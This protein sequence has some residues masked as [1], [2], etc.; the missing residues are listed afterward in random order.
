MIESTGPSPRRI[1]GVV[2]NVR[3]HGPEYDARPEVYL[4][5]GQPGARGAQPLRLVLR[6]RPSAVLSTDR[7]RQIAQAVGP[8]V[9]VGRLRSGSDDLSEVVVRPRHRTMLLSLLGGLGMVLTLV[10]IFSMTAYAVTRRTQEIGI[11]MAF[12][13]EP[14]DVVLTMVRDAAWPAFLGLS[15]GM[16]ARSCHRIIASFRSKRR[17]TIRGRSRACPA[18]GCCGTRRCLGARARAARVDPVIALRQSSA[19]RASINARAIA[20]K[21]SRYFAAKDFESSA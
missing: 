20:T 3:L 12:G 6:P 2:G 11:R 21:S 17:H 14:A 18:H 10:G 4:V 9:L 15:A 13:A 19:S 5:Y 16:A 1:I 7:L 8:R